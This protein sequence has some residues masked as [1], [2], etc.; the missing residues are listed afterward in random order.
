MSTNELKTAHVDSMKVISLIR[1][2]MTFGH[3]KADLDPLRMKDFYDDKILLE[4]FNKTGEFHNLIDYK[5]YGFTEADLDRTFV[6]DIPT[7]DGLLKRNK[8]WVLRDL[9]QALENAYCGKIGVEYMHI[10]SRSEC[11]WIRD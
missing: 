4:K 2:Y 7:I 9:I 3:L 1:A 5:F 11:N 6:V 8:T 10:E